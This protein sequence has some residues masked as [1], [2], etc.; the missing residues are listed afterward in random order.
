MTYK[1]C[2]LYFKWIDKIVYEII[3]KI[4]TQSFMSASSD[5]SLSF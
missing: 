3:T 1:K 5:L 4:F 2:V